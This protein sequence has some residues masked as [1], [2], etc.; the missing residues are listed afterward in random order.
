[1]DR[2]RGTF[3]ARAVLSYVVRAVGVGVGAVLMSCAAASTFVGPECRDAAC[4]VAGEEGKSV[5]TRW[6]SSSRSGSRS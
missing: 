4:W 5:G 6:A 1:M 2:G 3:W